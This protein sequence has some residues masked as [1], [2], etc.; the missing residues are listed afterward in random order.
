VKRN[1][2][3]PSMSVFDFSERHAT[4]ARRLTSNTPL[5]ALVLLDDPQYVEAYRV[6][7]ADVMKQNANGAEQVKQLFRRATRR[8]PRE[9]ELKHLETYY[10][11]ER[12]RF[13]AEPAKAQELLHVGVSPVD[14]SA[15]PAQLAALTNVAA[16]IMNTPD[17]YSIH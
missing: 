6:L 4:I 11:S 16:A 12:A 15:D 17:A 14:A 2:P 3:P 5:Q 13:A 7:A 10:S 9:S 1:N 8:W